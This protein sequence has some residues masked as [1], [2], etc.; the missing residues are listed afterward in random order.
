LELSLIFGIGSR[1]QK[2]EFKKINNNNL[3]R[4]GGREESDPELDS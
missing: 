1:N 3:G 4:G 2:S